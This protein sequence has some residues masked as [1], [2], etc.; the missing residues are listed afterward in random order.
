MFISHS[1][2]SLSSFLPSF[3]QHTQALHGGLKIIDTNTERIG[4]IPALVELTS[5][6]E[7]SKLC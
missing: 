1:T 3:Y 6:A 7:F 5:L 2:L 4:L